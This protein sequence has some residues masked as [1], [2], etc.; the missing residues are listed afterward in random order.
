MNRRS[1]WVKFDNVDTNVKKKV[2]LTAKKLAKTCKLYILCALATG[3]Q[4]VLAVFSL[5]FILYALAPGAFAELAMPDGESKTAME[6]ADPIPEVED[7]N[8]DLNLKFL[9]PVAAHSL[10]ILK[11]TF[12]R[13][14]EVPPSGFVEEIPTPPPL[15]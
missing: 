5:L 8:S 7:E 4:R 13:T 6:K 11:I 12:H 3:F 1:T 9:Q 14:D 15:L 2:V 10:S